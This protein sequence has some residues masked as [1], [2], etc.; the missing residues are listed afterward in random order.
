MPVPGRLWILPS[1]RHAGAVV[2]IRIM[3]FLQPVQAHEAITSWHPSAARKVLRQLN[4]EDGLEEGVG[5][6]AQLQNPSKIGLGS[7]GAPA[8]MDQC[9]SHRLDGDDRAGGAVDGCAVD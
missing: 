3:E 6:E 1:F 4:P 5:L 2:S 9:G 8:R 7:G